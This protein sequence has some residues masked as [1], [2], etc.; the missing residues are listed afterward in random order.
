MRSANDMT[1]FPNAVPTPGEREE[2]VL[3]KE[4]RASGPLPTDALPSGA[5][6]VLQTAATSHLAASLLVGHQDLQVAHGAADFYSADAG[7]RL[8]D[9]VRDQIGGRRLLGVVDITAYDRLY[10]QSTAVE[11]G[12]ISFLRACIERDRRDGPILL[13]VTHNLQAWQAAAPT[14]QGART[15]GLYRML[16]S[17]YKQIRS[18]TMDSDCPISDPLALAA[19]IEREFLGAGQWSLSECCYRNGQRF[20]PELVRIPVTAAG[21]M[22]YAPEDVL[23]ITGGTRGIGAAVAEHAVAQGCRRLV[24]MGREDLASASEDKRRR[25]QRFADQGVQ[26]LYHN[27]PL[28]DVDGLRSMVEDIHRR[29]GRITGV[30]HCAGAVGKNPPFLEKTADEIRAVCGPKMTGLATLHEALGQEPLRF[31]VLFSSVSGVAPDLAAGMSDYGMANAY[32][33]HYAAAQAAQG[34]T[35]FRSI[36]WPVWGEVGAAAGQDAT[37]AYKKTGLVP[38]TTAEG[39]SL[40]DRLVGS[41]STVSLPFVSEEMPAGFER[42]LQI[43]HRAAP[44]SVPAASVAVPL[45][46]RE[47][48]DASPDTRRWLREIFR[49]ESRP[50]AERPAE[51]SAQADEPAPPSAAAPAPATVRAVG[52]S[53]SSSRAPA[54]A[55]GDEIAIVGL[56]CRMP[57][58]RDKDAYWR[59]LTS[60]EVALRPVDADR[61]A[62]RGSRVDYGGWMDDVDRFDPAF[63]NIQEADAAIMDPQARVLLEESLAA[64]YDAGY[65]HK[66]LSGAKV[67]VYVGGRSQPNPDKPAVLAAPNPIL[68]SG[69][70]YLATNISRSFNFRGP[71]MVVD[72]ACSSGLAAIAIAVDALKCGR[73]ELALAGAI[74]VLHTPSTHDLFGARNILSREGKLELFCKDSSGDVLGEG[75]GVVLLKRLRDALR[76]GDA[77]YGVIRAIASNNDGR[78]LGPGSPSMA[79]QKQV[80]QEAL[81][82]A[83]KRPED[84]GYIEVNGGGSPVVDTIEI[85]ALAEAYRLGDRSLPPCSLGSVKPNVGHLLCAAGM[86]GFIRCVLSV[87]RAQIP[88][89]LSAH[90]PFEHYDFASSRIAFTRQTT[91]WEPGFG[92]TRVAALSSF[93]DGGTNFHVL[94]E[95]LVPDG[96]YR[97]R[98]WPAA[99]PQLARKSFPLTQAR[100][101]VAD[102][103]PSSIQNVWG[104]YDGKCL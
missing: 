101:D 4:W 100:R 26:V 79:A 86:A 83:G 95:Q 46:Q 78:T 54:A 93:P 64:I 52:A 37:P 20:E 19:Q 6:V 84:V 89:F 85:K 102:Q 68:G 18:V 9:Q 42:L 59:L 14:L 69:Q 48:V 25:L 61:W 49:A 44:M 27:T 51:A 96:E 62:P 88:P 104:R 5:V 57:G 75:A 3:V 103:P 23:L 82:E 29:A 71:S 47:Q 16:G 2:A 58:A 92:G 98:R 36:Q 80:I 7:E 99:P 67:G 40:L 22:S 60:G 87:S 8:Y 74:S 11:D 32:M 45:R 77:I 70:N 24:L 33:D 30:F 34:R 21:R 35:Y 56:A 66:E 97:Q 10:E 65:Q 55:R 41:P 12:K 28:T 76:D 1:V 73:I 63:F 50:S 13:Q 94:I 72:T 43:R 91:P 39:L 31:F 17:E 81:A 15:V 38:I 53:A 90:E